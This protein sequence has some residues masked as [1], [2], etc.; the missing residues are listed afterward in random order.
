MIE[1]ALPQF[2]WQKCVISSTQSFV[3]GSIASLQTCSKIVYF[4]LT[5]AESALDMCF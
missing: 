3:S 1:E 4:S 2:C 5:P